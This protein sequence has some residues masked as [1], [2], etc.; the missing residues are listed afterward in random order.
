M[1]Q[2]TPS[3]VARGAA[4]F[5]RKMTTT[6]PRNQKPT[7]KNSGK[8]A[9]EQVQ[10][11]AQQPGV[12]KRPTK[13]AAAHS[14]G[15]AAD[16]APVAPKVAPI[17][18]SAASPPSSGIGIIPMVF[19]LSALGYAGYVGYEYS[20][21]PSIANLKEA[22][23]LSK[24]REQFGKRAV[25]PDVT[26]PSLLPSLKKSSVK[27]EEIV[28]DVADELKAT[29][30]ASEAL[31][32]TAD[33]L[34]DESAAVTAAIQD[35]EDSVSD[36]IA[37]SLA[38]AGSLID[39]PS[40]P[41]VPL[42]IQGELETLTKPSK[43]AV[44]PVQESIAETGVKP[45]SDS[46]SESI[47]A[48]SQPESVNEVS[49]VEEAQ[50]VDTEAPSA[51]K[52]DIAV[53]ATPAADTTTVVDEEDSQV[54]PTQAATKEK[55]QLEG[56][57]VSEV[58]ED[59]DS[60]V[61]TGEL[62]PSPASKPQEVV[63]IQQEYVPYPVVVLADDASLPSREYLLEEINQRNQIIATV[64]D[65]LAKARS[66]EAATSSVRS[67]YLA[68]DAVE[69]AIETQTPIATHV[70]AL[71]AA[72]N[73]D[74]DPNASKLPLIMNAFR[75]VEVVPRKGDLLV[76]FA[77]VKTNAR[78][79]AFV[80]QYGGMWSYATSYLVSWLTF[81]PEGMVEGTDPEAIL[82]RA[83][84]YVQ[85]NDLEAAVREVNQLKGACRDVAQSWL[86]SARVALT[87]EMALKVLKAHLQLASLGE[88]TSQ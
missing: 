51:E 74:K 40:S 54:S 46:E 2:R 37:A 86:D 32:E 20:K 36:A 49:V 30:E 87:A 22:A 41:A 66:K 63:V 31:V 68:I 67:L 61:E 76:Q 18:S 8:A 25:A 35:V 29:G 14:V 82:A 42:D 72:I 45:E 39:A 11:Q 81:A 7:D 44:V 16:G 23:T 47:Q 71:Q 50:T 6:I 73:S 1:M 5:R 62:T 88:T 85:R 60:E 79:V 17:P 84:T 57:S 52:E 9:G 56:N 75:N 43:T 64:Q 12:H 15:A 69:R 33:T 65:Q 77:Q 19:G 48:D 55:E 58:V 80:P 34:V 78:K 3:R 38:A 10:A 26:L 59:Q 53:D 13:V 27:D 70:L 28:V 83:E 4:R 24:L 21:D